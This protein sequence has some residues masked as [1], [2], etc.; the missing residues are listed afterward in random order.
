MIGKFFT[1][2]GVIVSYLL[3]PF[4]I[5]LVMRETFMLP[6]SFIIGV[7]I[8]FV[9]GFFPLMLF[10]SR[11]VFRFPAQ[12]KQPIA[13]SELVTQIS[14]LKIKDCLFTAEQHDDCLVLTSPYMDAN[15]I[16]LSQAQSISKTYYMK[17]WF[18]EGKNLVRFKDHLVSSSAV[19]GVGGFSF[20]MSA[21]TGYVLSQIS[22][23]DSSAQLVRFS[24]GELHKALIEVVTA[25]GWDL[26]LKVI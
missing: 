7:V 11:K 25:N 23:L 17:L 14:K 24:N 26:N 5:A 20:N 21:Q 4:P 9:I 1:A 2:F 6:D 22:L 3:I 15:F 19:L 8:A 13:K 18:D 16:S 10:V 12:N